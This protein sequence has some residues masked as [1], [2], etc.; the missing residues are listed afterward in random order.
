M[1]RRADDFGALAAADPARYHHR[2]GAHVL[3]PVALHRV[4]GPGNRA[5]EVFGPT[6]AIPMCVGELGKRAPGEVV[7]GGGVDQPRAC[8]AIG[9][10]PGN[11]GGYLRVSLRNEDSQSAERRKG[12]P[13]GEIPPIEHPVTVVEL[14]GSRLRLAAVWASAG[15]RSEVSR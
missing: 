5:L 9:I 2:L 4:G 3:E 1:V 6:Q 7:A 8:L 12:Q 13:E 15:T 14:G 11:P 10:Q